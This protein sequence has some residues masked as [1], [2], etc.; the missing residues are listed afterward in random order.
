MPT[1][2]QQSLDYSGTTSDEEDVD[3]SEY[4]EICV[5]KTTLV[6]AEYQPCDDEV[7]GYAWYFVPMTAKVPAIGK[8]A[9]AGTFDESPP[10][11]TI[12]P[13]ERAARAKPS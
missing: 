4:V 12:E 5:R 8:K 3:E 7:K 2:S 1:P 11:P 6:R 13:R 10:R 9:R